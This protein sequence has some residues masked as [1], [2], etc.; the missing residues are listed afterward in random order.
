MSILPNV[1]E[2]PDRFNVYGKFFTDFPDERH[3]EF[4]QQHLCW[5][6][7]MKDGLLKYSDKGNI[8][9]NYGIE[10][11]AILGDLD[12]SIR[13]FINK[14]YKTDVIVPVKHFLFNF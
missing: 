7:H 3:T 1:L 10:E 5:G 13:N 4:E 14:D 8:V 6:Y 2:D 12:S 9:Q 11:K